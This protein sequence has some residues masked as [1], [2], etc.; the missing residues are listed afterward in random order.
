[1]QVQVS[2]T[3][4]IPATASIS[5]MEQ[6]IQEAGQQA[7]RGALKQAIRQWEDQRSSCLRCGEKQRRLEG[8]VRRTLATIFGRVE[9]PRRRFR[10]Q[11]C[12][13]RWCPANR[14]FADLK[15]GTIS[16]P[17]PRGGGPG[18]VFLALSGGLSAAE[19]AEWSPDQRGRTPF[20]DESAGQATGRAT[21]RGSRTSMLLPG[22]DCSR[23]RA[24][25]AADA[26][27]IGW[28]LGLQPRTTGRHGRES[29]GG[30]FSGGGCADTNLLP[31][32]FL[33]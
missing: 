30:L 33:E 6:Q 27:G 7:M 29:G 11:G 19:E 18:G 26:G 10:C 5:E 21:A 2:L 14:L 3:I 16:H 28:G 4:E 17:M 13:H 32:V 9:V 20:A 12:W 22:C 25:A 23:S 8:T 1:M 24:G 15:A 31:H